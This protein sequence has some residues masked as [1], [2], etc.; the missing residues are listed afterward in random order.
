MLVLAGGCLVVDGSS[1]AAASAEPSV[2]ASIFGW[3][4]LLWTIRL[5]LLIV[6]LGGMFVLALVFS[7]FFRKDHIR[8]LWNAPLPQFKEFGGKIAGMEATA[9][10]ADADI[11]TE[12]QIEALNKR[13]DELVEYVRLAAEVAA[14]PEP[15]PED[16]NEQA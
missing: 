12:A 6:I 8:R 9:K 2:F 11:A 7:R 13:I 15:Q 14:E 10:L 4:P 5:I 1:A 16:R 3:P